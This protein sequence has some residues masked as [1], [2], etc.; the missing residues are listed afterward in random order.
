MKIQ[1]PEQFKIELPVFPKFKTAVA[2]LGLALS[3]AATGTATLQANAQTITTPGSTSCSAGISCSALPTTV[4]FPNNHASVSG[5][6]SASNSQGNGVSVNVTTRTSLGSSSTG[7]RSDSFNV[8]ARTAAVRFNGNAN[9][10]NIH[11][12][13]AIGW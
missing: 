7:W 11:R 2:A 5:G 6:L 10:V 4:T 8:S 1:I 13:G 3:L 9:S 12:Q